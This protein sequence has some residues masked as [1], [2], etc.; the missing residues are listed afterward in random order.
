MNNKITKKM[1]IDDFRKKIRELQKNE[2]KL[3]ELE[4]LKKDYYKKYRG[5][6]NVFNQKQND[7][8]VVLD[9]AHDSQHLS[10]FE[11]N[12]LQ[13]A[14]KYLAVKLVDSYLAEDSYV[15]DTTVQK[16][17]GIYNKYSEVDFVTVN[18]QLDLSLSNAA[19]KITENQGISIQLNDDSVSS[20]Y[21]SLRKVGY[22]K[23][24]QDVIYYPIY[25]PKMIVVSIFSKYLEASE[26][27]RKKMGEFRIA[28][29]AQFSKI[30]YCSDNRLLQKFKMAVENKS[31]ISV[32]ISLSYEDRKLALNLD[33]SVVYAD[34]VSHVGKTLK[35]TVGFFD[36]IF[37]TLSRAEFNVYEALAYELAVTSVNVKDIPLKSFT[38]EDLR[39][40]KNAIKRLN[41]LFD[42]HWYCLNRYLTNGI[43]C[44]S[45]KEV[46]KILNSNY[47]KIKKA[48]EQTECD[49]KLLQDQKNLCEWLKSYPFQK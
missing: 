36:R 4:N 17:I 7:L 49:I 12:T 31:L 14:I 11:K 2:K 45:N 19:K 29:N 34:E 43:E 9:T 35:D 44:T 38:G 41:S 27:T 13:D 1:I 33:P 22:L 3:F 23:Y 21:S 26:D 24:D 47:K 20:L 16:I 5:Y 46:S 6:L 40:V 39:F 8:I 15:T 48:I 18:K 10:E 28:Y 25:E 32:L 37:P 30:L 42:M